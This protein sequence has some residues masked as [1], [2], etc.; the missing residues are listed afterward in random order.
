MTSGL[1]STY[2]RDAGQVV[3][4]GVPTG[5]AG[6]AGLVPLDG[7]EVVFDRA[8]RRLARVA[9]D[10]S[11]PDGPDDVGQAAAQLMD[12]FGKKIPVTAREAAAQG[13]QKGA[14]CPDARLCAIWSRLARLDAA[15]ATSPVAPASPL[16]AA[17]AA[18]LADQG[19]LHDRAQAEAR[20][21]VADL[22]ALLGS[23]PMP[24]A[25]S[26][27]ALRV[28]SLAEADEPAA[29]RK[30]RDSVARRPAGPP[31]TWIAEHARLPQHFGELEQQLRSD[32]EQNIHGLQWSVDPGVAPQG[33]LLPGLSPLSDLLVHSGAGH[34]HVIT[35]EALR[36]LGA[37]ADSVSHCWARLVDPAARRV[38]AVAPFRAA[39]PW[40]R[41][42]IRS[43][44]RMDE[45][46]GTW[47]EVVQDEHR[48]V[49]S[50][51]LRRI[52]R[53]LRWADT[54]LRA[55]QHPQGLGPR[56]T[57]EDWRAL[58]ALS[59]ERCR[60]DWQEAGDTGRAHLAAVRLAA[61]DLGAHMPGAAAA[62]AA[63]LA[64]DLGC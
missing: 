51:R 39:G 26:A 12:L 52:R 43:P 25:L 32:G 9:V 4:E 19:G 18:Q 28:A 53:A 59:W 3:L 20:G 46:S 49:Q 61:P 64:E 33:V 14:F 40:A 41:A 24:Q 27:A 23:T 5:A 22:A 8:D 47:I 54:A 63:F 42:K 30:L 13:A 48:P 6:G 56:F 44:F 1:T 7:L 15:R 29:A 35:A 36:P 34:D 45:L 10:A 31:R 60:R 17:E 62:E 55:E 50:Q 57:D 37:S 21:A 58:A 16:W 2:D 11:E 38:L